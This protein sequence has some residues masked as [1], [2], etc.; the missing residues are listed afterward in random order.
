MR[1]LHQ[2][3]H[4]N[5]L[6]HDD[7]IPE[8]LFPTT[9]KTKKGLILPPGKDMPDRV[10]ACSE[11]GCVTRN[12]ALRCARNT[13]SDACC[14]KQQCIPTRKL[15]QPGSCASAAAASCSAGN[16]SAAL[17]QG[18]DICCH[19]RFQAWGTPSQPVSAWEWKSKLVTDKTL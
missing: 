15:R 13:P 18:R 1:H 19:L 8:T 11:K 17:Q 6:K 10:F 9:A 5:H 12:L 2:H 14:A 3:T 4:E 7:Q 16:C